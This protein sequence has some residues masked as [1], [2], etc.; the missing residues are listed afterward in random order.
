MF[1]VNYYG[2]DLE[3]KSDSVPPTYSLTFKIDKEAVGVVLGHCHRTVK[4][5]SYM[6]HCRIIISD[7][8]VTISSKSS[9]ALAQSN[10]LRAFWTIMS[11][12]NRVSYAEPN[13]VDPP[14]S[15]F[16]VSEKQEKEKEKEKE[17]TTLTVSNIPETAFCHI[18]GRKGWSVSAIAKYHRVKIEFTDNLIISSNECRENVYAAYWACVSAYYYSIVKYFTAQLNMFSFS[19][20]S[21]SLPSLH[22]LPL[23]SLSSPSLPLPSLS[24][25][26]PSYSYPF[27]PHPFPSDIVPEQFF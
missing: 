12:V 26:L 2:E 25:P 8:V 11:I 20:P 9:D 27:F 7:D 3:I 6:T 18:I 16:I 19:L 4:R 15:Y 1:T 14:G 23:P 17:T 13:H 5:I 10:I 21:L 24:A 22:S